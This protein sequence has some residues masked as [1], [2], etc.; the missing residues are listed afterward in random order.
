MSKI[1]AW[2][3]HLHVRSS[4]ILERL[5]LN[6]CL[7]PCLFILGL[8]V[9]YPSCLRSLI[10]IFFYIYSFC[11]ILKIGTFSRTTILLLSTKHCKL[12]TF[13]CQPILLLMLSIFCHLFLLNLFMPTKRVVTN[14]QKSFFLFHHFY[15]N[16]PFFFVIITKLVFG[17]L[18][19]VG[20]R[21]FHHSIVH[22]IKSFQWSLKS[23]RKKSQDWNRFP[24]TQIYGC[25]YWE[26]KEKKCTCVTLKKNKKLPN[27]HPENDWR[28]YLFKHC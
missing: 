21:T 4:N 16:G 12:E 17:H 22:K 9:W 1:L 11:E 18:G 19:W 3:L 26:D 10:L 14:V 15:T 27:P 23:Q 13:F 25:S 6:L 2:T 8:S 28:L 24:E 5:Y 20:F 7:F